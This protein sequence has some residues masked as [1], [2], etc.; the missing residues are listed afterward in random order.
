M[1]RGLNINH[2]NP[3]IPERIEVHTALCAFLSEIPNFSHVPFYRIF[4]LHRATDKERN[5]EGFFEHRGPAGCL[6]LLG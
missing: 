2:Q 3:V 5:F 6:L 1:D 4:A